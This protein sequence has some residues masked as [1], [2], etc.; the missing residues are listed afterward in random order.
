MDVSQRP[1]QAVILAGGQGTRLRPLTLTVPKPMVQVRGKP[2]LEYQIEQLRDQGFER[3]L[4]LLG[5]LPEVVRDYFGDGRRWGLSIEYS[6]TALDDDTGRRIKLAEALLDNHFLLLYCDNYWP[7]DFA[8]MW[9][10]FVD[11]QAAAMITVYRNR[12]GYTRNSVRVEAD[13]MVSIY[14]KSGSAPGLNGVEISYA[15]LGKSITKLLTGDNQLFETTVYPELAKRRQLAGF[16]SDHRY[17]SVGAL[18]RLPLT[19]EFFR[20]KKTVILDRDGVLNEKPA[21]AHYVRDWS[22]FVWLPGALDA[23]RLL[24]E[25]DYRIIIV[26]NQAGIARG[27]MSATALAE[28]HSRM[29]QAVETAGG[30][31]AAIYTCPHD[32]DEGCDCRKPAPGMLFAAQRDFHLDLSRCYFFGDDERDATAA[33]RAGC[34]FIQVSD[35]RPL[36]DCVRRLVNINESLHTPKQTASGKEIM[37][38]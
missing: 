21:R 27:A 23:L 12:D 13:G 19:E 30:A 9:R 6:V 5:Y 17:Y 20:R 24:N 37:Y 26:S 8:A 3:V 38:G 18:H 22:E 29:E 31:I 1:T 10:F 2:F 36:I 16:V 35:S 34:R 4:L 32:W 28:L 11:R 33:Q 14:D 7:M 15:I 25:N